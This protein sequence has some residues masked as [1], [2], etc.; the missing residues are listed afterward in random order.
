VDPTLQNVK[1]MR[2]PEAIPDQLLGLP[3]EEGPKK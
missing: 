1:L 2:P 3:P